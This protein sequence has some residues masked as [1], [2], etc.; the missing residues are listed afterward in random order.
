MRSET[1]VVF[2]TDNASNTEVALDCDQRKHSKT[3]ALSCFGFGLNLYS[4]ML[5][6]VNTVNKCTNC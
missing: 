1:V 4:L 5:L 6:T 3:C 2:I